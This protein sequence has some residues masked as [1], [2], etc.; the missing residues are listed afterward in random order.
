MPICDHFIYTSAKTERKEGYQIIVRS[1]GISDELVSDLRGYL[2]PVGLDLKSFEESRSLL[3]LSNNK[4]AYSIV[5]NIGAGYDARKGTLYNHT[6]VLDRPEFQELYYDSRI[7]DR[8]FIM[9][10]DLRGELQKIR[11]EYTRI[12]IKFES[13]KAISSVSLQHLLHH[14]L[15]KK[16]IALIIG[17]NHLDLIQNFLASLPPSLRLISFS[18]LVNEPQ[19]QHEYD[20]IQIPKTLGYKLDEGWKRIEAS[21]SRTVS[22]EMQSIDESKE[23]RY[24]ADL[25]L[26][27]DEKMLRELHEAFEHLPG[28][29]PYSKIRFLAYKHLSESAQDNL[30]R[31]EYAYECAKAVRDLNSNLASQY[32]RLAKQYSMEARAV[33]LLSRIEIGELALSMEK[34]R[35]SLRSVEKILDR[36]RESDQETRTLLLSKI[37]E[38]KARD[39]PEDTYAL[40]KETVSSDSYYKDDI[41]WLFVA[42]NVFNSFV[43]RLIPEAK[44][45]MTYQ[46]Y[47]SLLEKFVK[48]ALSDN[49]S[50][51]D[52]LFTAV[53]I[54]LTKRSELTYLR[55]LIYMVYADPNLREIAPPEIIFNMTKKIR[56]KFD[57]ALNNLLVEDPSTG[58]LKWNS[59]QDY[60]DFK[61]T[62]FDIMHDML[63]CLRYVVDYR[64]HDLSQAIRSSILDEITMIESLL[65]K[66]R[67]VSYKKPPHEYRPPT[68]LEWWLAW[69]GIKL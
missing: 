23:L 56:H 5:K 69:W 2:Y 47:H 68:W 50:L 48:I 53:D 65:T 42:N 44:K 51:L 67:S 9:D 14:F 49:F 62:S 18:T 32:L 61:H 39:L 10:P 30:E 54:N 7:L 24:M 43:L 6:F 8:F 12:P 22:E 57:T 34:E 13:L 27:E 46:Q 58:R 59:E 31:A 60:E 45:E 4:I 3:L 33:D 63:R 15:L 35:L 55:K 52:E 25:I 28:I 40:L 64:K 16:K 36:L 20:F 66:L 41:L 19:K 37:L 21:V 38:K 1:S 26:T 29:D 17:G 11:I